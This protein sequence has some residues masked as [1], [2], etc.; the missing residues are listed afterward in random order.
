VSFFFLSCELW[1]VKLNFLISWGQAVWW[2]FSRPTN[3]VCTLMPNNWQQ[4]RFMYIYRLKM[5]QFIQKLNITRNFNKLL[6]FI[7]CLFCQNAIKIVIIY[8][9]T[10]IH[11]TFINNSVGL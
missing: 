3:M 6:I 8:I 10:Y 7:F 4:W 2:S 11:I 9:P 1:V 5:Q